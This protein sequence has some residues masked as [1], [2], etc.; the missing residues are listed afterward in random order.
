MSSYFETSR[1]PWETSP[2][3]FKSEVLN[4]YIND[5]EK[6]S[7]RER[8]ISCRG[9]WHLPTFDTNEQGQVHTL[10]IYLTY[11]PFEELC[12]WRCYNE[13]PKGDISKRSFDT[14]FLAKFSSEP[15]PLKKLKNI[16]KKIWDL[17]IQPENESLWLPH[18]KNFDTT[19]FGFY[20]FLGG[21]YIQWQNYIQDLS[22]I[23]NDGLSKDTI[24]KISKRLGCYDA[25]LGSIK[26]LEK[27]L[28]ELSIQEDLIKEIIVPFTNLQKVR[29]T[30]TKAHRERAKPN[31]SD[32][33]K[34]AMDHLKSII[35]ALVSLE[36]LCSK[37]KLDG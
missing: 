2:V 27:C 3:F 29:S 18:N 36:A 7:I 32:L 31:S 17:K 14:D 6:Y 5:P 16:L 11:L 12:H 22:R 34:D 30:Q 35:N 37:R 13:P 15:E 20:Y 25:R 4:K 10:A 26:L 9:G 24:N 1:K 28:Q 19:F 21:G 23:V 8:D 33:K